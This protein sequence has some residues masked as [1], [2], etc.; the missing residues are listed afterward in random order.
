MRQAEIGLQGERKGCVGHG[1][2]PGPRTHQS[3]C[4]TLRVPCPQLLPHKMKKQNDG[5]SSRHREQNYGHQWAWKGW[6][7]LG[8]CNRHIYTIDTMYEADN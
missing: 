6:D 4:S 7:E 5:S 2:P 3:N 1:H 8:D